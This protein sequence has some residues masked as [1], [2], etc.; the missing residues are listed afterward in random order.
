MK[1]LLTALALTVC[2]AGAFAQASAPAAAAGKAHPCVDAAKAKGLK[3]AELKKDVEA[4]RAEHKQKHEKCAADAKAKGLKKAE[5]SA[6]VKA[7]MAQ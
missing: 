2:A 7:C 6:A 1:K 5:A 4:C 3:G